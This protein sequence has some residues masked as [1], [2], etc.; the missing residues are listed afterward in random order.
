M[1][2][3]TAIFIL[4]LLTFLSPLTGVYAATVTPTPTTT[5][6]VTTTPTV[7]TTPAV[8]I[9]AEK[10][11]E[12][13]LTKELSLQIPEE[14]DDPSYPVTFVDPSKQGVDVTVDEK[15]TNKASSPFVLQNLAIGEHTIVFK[16][17][18]KDG[19]VRV[20]T[21]KLIVTPKPPVLD[22]KTPT[23]VVFPDKVKFYG[24]ALPASTIVI[25]VN[26]TSTHRT[27]TNQ[28]GNW[29]FTLSEPI[30]GINTF[31]LYSMRNRISSDTTKP[32]SITYSKS[33]KALTNGTQDPWYQ[34]ALTE[35]ESGINQF[36]E[37]KDTTPVAFYGILGTIAVLGLILVVSSIR[38]K[39]KKVSEDK[40]FAEMFEQIKNQNTII[41][42]LKGK[43]VKSKEEST[44]ETQ[45]FK[46]VE[47]PKKDEEKEL[48]K[49]KN[50]KKKTSK[51]EEKDIIEDTKINPNEKEKPKKNAFISR[52][53]SL[54]S[55]EKE[56]DVI[57]KKPEA[58]FVVPTLVEKEQK[59]T[60]SE[61][62]S[63]S[64]ENSTEIIKKKK[65]KSA[66]KTPA[67]TV[68][69]KE[70][71]LKQFQSKNDEDEA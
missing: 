29:E 68:L 14:T 15:T 59:S 13:Q 40:S 5:V 51:N 11:R 12:K 64:E 63:I 70:E 46:V 8:V 33:A 27:T 18:T 49:V 32:I 2:K 61:T 30:N 23:S 50:T 52:L 6:K 35:I 71:F 48:E 10:E 66:V 21:K 34:Q 58:T 19:L 53:L 16:Y 4:A 60:T 44:E 62:P 9:D 47:S 20:L 65:K 57:D 43:N 31:I 37:L 55:K 67:K 38:G 36:I 24:T 42:V 39:S 1:K 25:I 26:G 54:T 3:I 69:S 28:E 41:D 17:K 56:E 7:K 22:N 45:K